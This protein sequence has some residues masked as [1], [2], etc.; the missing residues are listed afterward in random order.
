MLRGVTSCFPTVVAAFQVD[1]ETFSHVFVLDANLGL[2]LCV[3]SSSTESTYR[4]GTHFMHLEFPYNS[5]EQSVCNEPFKS[6]QTGVR[7][8]LDLWP[9]TEHH[10]SQFRVYYACCIVG[11]L[12]YFSFI[13]TRGY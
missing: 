6:D 8:G 10:P 2:F 11:V 1:F 4:H 9:Y 5:Q 13:D 12:E 7:T 3:G